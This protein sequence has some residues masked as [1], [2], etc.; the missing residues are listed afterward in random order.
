MLEV[1]I[2]VAILAWMFSAAWLYS[3]GWRFKKVAWNWTS[4]CI[5]YHGGRN[6]VSGKPFLYIGLGPF[7]GLDFHKPEEGHFHGQP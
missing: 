4:F 6:P 7:L 5:G 1:L 3:G 2:A